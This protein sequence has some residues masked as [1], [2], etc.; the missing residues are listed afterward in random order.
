[1]STSH[2]SLIQAM[3]Q[4]RSVRGYTDAAI[5][6]ETIHKI[7]EQA[8]A[9]P[10][11][12]NVQPWRVLLATGDSCKTLSKQLTEAFSKATPMN[13]DFSGLPKFSGH[14]RD[15]QVDC[16][17]AL[18]GAMSIDRKDHIARMQA[19]KKNYEFFNAPHVMFFCMNREYS[20]A[21]AV[22]VGMYAQNVMLLLQAHGIASCAQASTAY[23][24][25]IIRDFFEEPAE[26]G[27]L[28]GL[29][30]GYEDTEVAANNTRTTRAP[31][32]QVLNEKH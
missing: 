22:D 10:S 14:Q 23:Y 2:D 5:P 3:Q 30:F 12:C 21:M 19:T 29:S 31:L 1:M 28:F 20:P 15:R 26:N 25:E 18:Y 9:S 11:N 24:P 6:L 8:Q 13:P 16:A 4:R 27:I 7:L 32:D 17:M